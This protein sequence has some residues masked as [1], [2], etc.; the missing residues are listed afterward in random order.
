MMET[1]LKARKF[2]IV[3]KLAAGGDGIERPYEYVDHP[4]AVVILPLLP[5]DQIVILCHY[6]RVLERELW[7]LPAGT[8]DVPGETPVE[9]A[10]RELAE[11]TGYR[12]GRLEP[13]C[14]FYPSPGVLTELIRAYVGHDLSPSGL[15]LDETE[16]IQPQRMDF[17]EALAMVRDGRIV[18]GKTI[19]TLLRWDAELRVGP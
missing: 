5:D 18:D 17:A 11:E 6:R 3:R 14:E 16:R 13:L 8:L 2:S 19:I 12:A 9:A 4:G 7:E 15:P 10:G 1:L